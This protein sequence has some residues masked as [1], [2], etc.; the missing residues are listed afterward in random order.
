MTA[1]RTRTTPPSLPWADP[2]TMYRQSARLGIELFEAGAQS[3]INHQVEIANLKR[4]LTHAWF[5]AARAAL[6]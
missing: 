3:Y 5:S 1:R 4:G 6:R 2:A